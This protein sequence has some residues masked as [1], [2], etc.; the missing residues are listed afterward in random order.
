MLKMQEQE[1]TAGC[2]K[3]AEIGDLRLENGALLPDVKI[4]YETYGRLN[5]KKDNAVLI[6]HALTGTAHASGTTEQPGWWDGLV[7]PEK[8]LDTEK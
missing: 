4:A 7:G 5:A 6:C 2:L 1:E 8:W 3:F